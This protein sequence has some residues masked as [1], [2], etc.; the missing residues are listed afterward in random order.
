MSEKQKNKPNY[1]AEYLRQ[2][3]MIDQVVG[4]ELFNLNQKTLEALDEKN[5]K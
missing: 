4:L 5:S 2:I 1:L 3:Y